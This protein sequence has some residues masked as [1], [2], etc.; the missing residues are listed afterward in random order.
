MFP[1]W[2]C[3]TLPEHCNGEVL[4]EGECKKVPG[5]SLDVEAMNTVTEKALLQIQE[6]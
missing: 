5:I 2:D 6:G 1:A 3:I 4:P